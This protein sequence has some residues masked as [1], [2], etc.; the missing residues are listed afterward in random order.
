ME[1][2]MKIKDFFRKENLKKNKKQIISIFIF[3]LLAVLPYIHVILKKQSFSFFSKAEII[4][5]FG[6][7]SLFIF[8]STCKNKIAKNIIK[9]P[10]LILYFILTLSVYSYGNFLN[11]SAF[12]SIMDSNLKESVGYFNQY[13]Y[14]PMFVAFVLT[15]ILAFFLSQK[16]PIPKKLNRYINVLF[17]L[18]FLGSLIILPLKESL[19]KEKRPDMIA[20]PLFRISSLLT[21]SILNPILQFLEYK[22]DNKF[23]N[24]KDSYALPDYVKDTGTGQYKHIFMIIGEASS[25]R[26]YAYFGYPKKTTPYLNETRNDKNIFCI[27]NSIAPAAT[28][29]EVLKRI[30]GFGTIKDGDSFFKFMNII[31]AAKQKGYET[32]WYSSQGEYGFYN[33]ITTYIG[34]KAQDHDF[35]FKDPQLLSKVL[36]KYDPDKKQFFVIHFQGSHAP[37]KNYDPADKKY[38]LETENDLDASY[39]ATIKRSDKIVHDIFEQASKS[40]ASAAFY[41][42]DHGEVVGKGHGLAFPSKEQYE[43]PFFVFD[44]TPNRENIKNMIEKMRQGEKF[45]TQRITEVIFSFLGY[46]VDVDSLDFSPVPMVLDS[47]FKAVKF[48]DIKDQY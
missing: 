32:Y 41:F 8:T 3:G 45:N 43:V 38:F 10:I 4:L 18:F 47:N 2:P 9:C 23:F 29:R 33:S 1:F 42:S 44:N 34:V 36:E 5:L 26:R 28:T 21:P 24:Y 14:F 22:N 17:L 27:Q 37:Y 6:T 7:F 35:T 15:A 30:L 19:S 48:N 13:G 16:N 25:P 11:I 39:D 20:A 40:A 46:K 12:S 31:Y